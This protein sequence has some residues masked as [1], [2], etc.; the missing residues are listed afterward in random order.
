MHV[1]LKFLEIN[2]FIIIYVHIAHQLQNKNMRTHQLIASEIWVVTT[3]G[4]ELDL[5]RIGPPYFRARRR[6]QLKWGFGS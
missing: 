2:I 5:K 6:R 1:S 4:K 3:S